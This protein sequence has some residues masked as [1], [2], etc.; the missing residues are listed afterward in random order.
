MSAI[1]GLHGTW[2]PRAAIQVTTQIQALTENDKCLDTFPDQIPVQVL[3]KAA[4]WYDLE[5]NA[6][7]NRELAVCLRNCGHIDQAIVF[8]N[9]ALELDPRFFKAR[10]DLAATYEAKGDHKKAI[11]VQLENVDGIRKELNRTIDDM[12]E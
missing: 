2:F 11:E 3:L 12:Q 10:H 4:T 5:Q 7:W 1:E 8:F 9:K 6:G